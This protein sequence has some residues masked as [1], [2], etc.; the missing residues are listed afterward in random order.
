MKK[1][2]LLMLLIPGIHVMAQKPGF[3]RGFTLAVGQSKFTPINNMTMREALSFRG[4]PTIREQF[5]PHLSL[6][7]TPAFESR[8]ARAIGGT[9]DGIDTSGNPTVYPFQD[10]YRLW[11][12]NVP[13]IAGVGFGIDN[14]YFKAIGGVMADFNI[15]GSQTRTYDD[16]EYNGNHGYENAAMSN[17]NTTELQAMAGFELELDDE[18]SLYGLSFGMLMPLSPAGKINGEEF[19]VRSFQVGLTLFTGK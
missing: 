6:E 16:L 4:G 19:S 3:Y 5:T 15:A 10:R 7:C 13:L 17:I 2:F 9:S 18:G 11:S 8:G 14:L 12:V 1:F